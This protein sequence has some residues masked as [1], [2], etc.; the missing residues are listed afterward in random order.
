MNRILLAYDGS[1]PSKK[2][3]QRAVSL[4]K[5]FGATLAVV[6]VV[7]RGPGRFPIDPWDDRTTHALELLEARDLLR[8]MGIEAELIEPTGDPAET[9]ES[10]AERGGYDV[11]VVGSRGQ[12]AIGRLLQGSVSE[13]LAT[14]AHATVVVAR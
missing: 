9:I 11:I 10:V 13:H 8:E 6:S 12:G 14:H 2:A 7:P 4:C 1:E 5:A 3:L